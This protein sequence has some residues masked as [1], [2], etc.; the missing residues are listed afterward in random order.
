MSSFCTPL[1]P[2]PPVQWTFQVINPEPLLN[3]PE[4]KSA[5]AR[6]VTDYSPTD[7]FDKSSS[8]SSGGGLCALPSGVS[9]DYQLLMGLP[10]QS[11]QSWASACS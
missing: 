6:H 2:T 4:P 9:T 1:Y 8:W 10:G 3:P 11:L 7:L 5:P